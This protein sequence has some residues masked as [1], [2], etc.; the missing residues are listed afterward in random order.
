MIRDEIQS[1]TRRLQAVSTSPRLDAE[2]LLAHATGLS[3]GQ[4]AARDDAE[5]EPA[6]AARFA[7][8]VERRQRGEPLAYLTGIRE[9]WTL[10][11]EVGPGVLVPRPETELLVEHGLA[12]L[13]DVG[14]PL[15]LDLGAGSGAVGLAIA[16]AR[17]DARV[18]LVE[19]S[20]LALTYARTN[21]ARLGAPNASLHE[22]CW[23]DP[24]TPAR[25]DLI[26]A[27]PPYLADSDPHLA[28]PEIG[29]EPVEALVAGPSGLE[30]IAEIAAG[31]PDHLRPGGH[32]LAE[33]GSTQGAG[34]RSLFLQ[35]GLTEVAT[36][37][38]LAGLE[39]ATIGRLPG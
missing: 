38:D 1:A 2:L 26:V 5:L 33:H 22:G 35:A 37:R 12:L 24:V 28:G 20:P 17:P 7:A 4:L 19:A 31:A 23:F 34:A 39:R 6:T 10:A 32:L 18:D 21:L 36:L 30:C 29:H 8:L 13:R 3:R 25:Y 27:N 11:L 14:S 9:F 16:S 15:V